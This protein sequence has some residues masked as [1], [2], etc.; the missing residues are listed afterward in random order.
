MQTQMSYNFHHDITKHIQSL[1]LSY[2]NNQDSTYL[3]QRINSDTGSLIVFC[4][5]I[6]NN[7]LVNLIMIIAPF[8]ILLTMNWF[9]TVLL[10]GFLLLYAVLYTAFKKPIY[11]AGF[12]LKEAQGK[13]FSTLFEQLKHI[14]LIKTNSIQPEISRRTDSGFVRFK[15]AAVHNQKVSYV[16]SGMDGF[17]STLAQIALFVVGG[18]QVL[19]GN[20]TIGMFTIFTS[21][22]TMILGSSRYFFGLGASYQHTL[23]AY[24]R[25]K[26]ILNLKPEGGGR[27]IID[28]VSKIQATDLSFSYAVGDT[29][30]SL[31][32]DQK[33][34]R[35][36]NNRKK[37][38]PHEG[39]N[40]HNIK[41][42]NPALNFNETGSTTKANPKVNDIIETKRKRVLEGLSI[43]LTKGKIYTL[44]G[45]NGSGK[46][47]LIS[48]M[49]GMYADEYDGRITYDGTDIK[50]IDM[51]A[52]RRSLIGFAEQE[53]TLIKDSILFNLCFNESLDS[54]CSSNQRINNLDKHMQT[55][56]MNDFIDK[57]G[58]HFPLN[59]SNTN[60]SGGEKQKISIL[61]VLLKDP[62][63][64]IFDEP[65]SALDSD[66][67]ERFM[68]YL[69]GIKSNKIIVIVTHDGVV[70][71]MC[72]ER[73]CL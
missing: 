63:V 48:L 47:T 34:R 64:M 46:S 10:A 38:D 60:T 33:E 45:S 20:F 44:S 27:K 50:D 70:E 19:S 13:F 6:L 67:T 49:M 24:D 9:I 56:G 32:Q 41:N 11:N 17:I 30:H 35:E 71:E 37:D 73:V 5:T 51:I 69:Q 36:G 61:K 65:T 2:T 58:L 68:G 16:Y 29:S 31:S 40:S 21:Y 12:R 7:V 23:V 42:H 52:A 72:D 62:P 14:K 43:E 59:E 18:L 39:I 54:L 28:S 1:S 66:A 8:I 25:V 3:N 4:I 57:N 22:F 15:A 26:E 53:P 55:L